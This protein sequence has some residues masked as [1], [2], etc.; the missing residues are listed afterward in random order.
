M[1]AECCAQWVDKKEGK[2]KAYG[3]NLRHS[4]LTSGVSATS[5]I[6]L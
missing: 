6:T 2:K 5:S 1:A 3:W 4:W